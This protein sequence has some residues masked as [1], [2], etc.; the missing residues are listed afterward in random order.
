MTDKAVGLIH[1][2]DV[3]RTDG[4]SEP[5]GKH[6][7]CRYFVLDVTHDPIALIAIGAYARS[8]RASGYRTLADDLDRLIND[9]LG[10]VR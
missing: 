5:G 10:G 9:R 8:A 2:F 3:T 4:T 6:D 1:K 7:G